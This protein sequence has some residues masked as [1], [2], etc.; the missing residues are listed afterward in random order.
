[1]KRARLIVAVLAA[2]LFSGCR[3][4]V[5]GDPLEDVRLPRND[6]A[7][8]AAALQQA[9]VANDIDLDGDINGWEEWLAFGRAW[10]Q[11][12]Q[13]TQKGEPK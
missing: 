8:I 6:V 13:A 10:V 11:A 12:Y 2:F 3:S 4:P 7:G 9:I 5:I 1:M